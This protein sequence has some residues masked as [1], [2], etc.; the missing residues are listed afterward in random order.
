MI[1]TLLSVASELLEN[2]E[3]MFPRYYM[4]SDL[5][6]MLKSST[7]HQCVIRRRRGG[8]EVLKFI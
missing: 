8:A 1:Y 3:E 7:T 6:S 2:V 4:H 5:F